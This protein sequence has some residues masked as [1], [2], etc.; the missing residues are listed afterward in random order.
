M[1]HDLDQ[2][3]N[4]VD[5]SF[6]SNPL[7]S[8]PFC[9]L[10]N[11]ACDIAAHQLIEK[12]QVDIAFLN[13][14][15]FIF[16]RELDLTPLSLDDSRKR[17]D[18]IRALDPAFIRLMACAN[19]N[20]VFPYIH[21]EIY[22]F[23]RIDQNTSAVNYFSKEAGR[24]EV[25]D[26]VLTNL[27]ISFIP[28]VKVDGLKQHM[29]AVKRR[30]DRREAI[31][32]LAGRCYIE[33]IYEAHL[34]SYNEAAIVPDTLY[35]LVGFSSAK[36]YRNIRRAIYAICKSYIDTLAFVHYYAVKHRL[37]PD[38]EYELSKGL[39]MVV[40]PRQEI[41]DLVLSLSGAEET[42]FE[43]FAEFFFENGSTRQSLS[44]RFLPPFWDLCGTVY[45]SPGAA[46]I[47]LS[48]RNILISIQ[49]EPIMEKKYDFHKK[50]S[51]LF[52]PALLE[53]AKRHFEANGIAVSLE[54]K[55]PG[56]DIDLLAYCE[57]SNTILTV[58][59]KAT[60]Y[61][62]G[63]RMVKNLD[64][65]INEA[66]VQLN[67]FDNLS[68]DEQQKAINTC[69]PSVGDRNP[70]RL[71]AVLLNSSF[72]SYKSWQLL[73]SKEI[74]PLNC[75]IL[76]NVLPKC[77]DLS[78]LHSEVYN[79]I[80]DCVARV[81]PKLEDKTFDLDGHVIQQKNWDFDPFVLYREGLMGE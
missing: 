54:K 13:P 28:Q 44:K 40:V 67:V 41:K 15:T 76:R 38:L 64:F 74:L 9:V 53:R 47:S 56:T 43:K 46:I 7:F 37:D 77:V 66:V 73:E 14:L 71:N 8:L 68:A 20:L 35:D 19:L 5:A 10:F 17:V 50:I 26:A 81:D 25:Q 24:I 61:P 27:S 80:N 34:D 16:Q 2:I 72:G 30:L 6:D 33:Q 60:L 31:Q 12:H 70:R 23:E 78:N 59:A 21:S 22:R 62:E 48:S 51:K 18:E 32:V 75:N 49:N 1:K 11:L 65:R 52:E 36:A 3:E 69:F 58:Q 63:A 29:E 39:S 42:D 79:Y 57:R 4:L 55:V 45:F